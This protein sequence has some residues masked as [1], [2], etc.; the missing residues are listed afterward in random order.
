MFS[1][2]NVI[3]TQREFFSFSVDNV[4]FLLLNKHLALDCATVRL[5]N[6]RYQVQQPLT[7]E[8]GPDYTIYRAQVWDH[9]LE[10][11]ALLWHLKPDPDNRRTRKVL[12]QAAANARVLGQVGNTSPHLPKVFDVSPPHADELW[13]VLEWITGRTLRA[14]YPNR[15]SVPDGGAVYGLIKHALDVCDAL[16]A[17]HKLHL[18]HLAVTPHNIICSR[19]HRKTVL[20]N[21]TLSKQR[22]QMV[23]PAKFL[24]PEQTSLRPPGVL[25]GPATDI[26]GL[27]ATLYAI[28]T[29]ESPVVTRNRS[30]PPP[31]QFNSQL[32]KLLN[33]A[34]LT[35]LAYQP[36]A[37]FNHI[38]QFK[39]ALYQ[40]QRS[41]RGK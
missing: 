16:T 23:T 28:L 7:D 36:K 39:Q 34:L 31:S 35:A 8:K 19:D 9:R 1:G 40:V 20:I 24:A 41:M 37:R 5:D 30:L 21:P 4:Q 26:Y 22:Q 27:A 14:L 10:R 12:R 32:P 6:N 2:K 33:D 15:Q 25:P 13:V 18:A 17:L 11:L 3:L 29:G 38:N